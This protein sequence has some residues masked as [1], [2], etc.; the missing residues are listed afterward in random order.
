MSI[1]SSKSL[2]S[3]NKIEILS[4]SS[5]DTNE[6]SLCVQPEAMFTIYMRLS[7]WR[8]QL[9]LRHQLFKAINRNYTV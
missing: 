2:S 9:Y 7:L 8:N 3:S 1:S 5:K 4:K 6:A